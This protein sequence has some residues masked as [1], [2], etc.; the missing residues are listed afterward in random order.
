MSL[1]K[2][3]TKKNGYI[4]LII[5]A[6]VT[7]IISTTDG[8]DFDVYLGAAKKLSDGQNIYAPPFVKGL[9]YYYS[10][11]FALLLIPFHKFIFVTEF[12]WLL[13]SYYWLYRIWQLCKDYFDID[14]LT[15][16]QQNQWLLFTFLLALQFIMYN[17]SVIQVTIFLLWAIL[18]SLRL[19][20]QKKEI[21]AGL[22]LA[23]IINIKVMPV[24]ILP[25]LFYR[26]YFKS[27]ITIIIASVA[28]IYLPAIFI[29]NDY[30]NF[31]LAEWWKIINPQNKEH[32]FET[33]IGPHSLVALI[34]VYLIDTTGDLPYKRNFVNLDAATVKLVINISRLLLLA[35]SFFYLRSMPFRKETNKLKS[36]WEISYFLLIIPLLM[37]HQMKY[38]FLFSLPM[39]MYLLYF[40]FVTWKLPRS[41]AYTIVLIVFLVTQI[42]FYSP[43]YGRDLIGKF[44]FNYTQHFRYLTI[45]TLLLIPVSLY[46]SPKKISAVKKV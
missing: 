32:L 39:I 30:N 36:F 15:G 25:Y 41:T 21:T 26:G 7:S 22:L 16:K 27:I 24:L 28:L 37:P 19:I 2:Y 44:L 42:F 9:Q 46:C 38:A 12:I 29:G 34:P 6:V 5:I 18:E 10:V 35:I 17:I 43:V 33:N 1:K 14:R 20:Q 31:L 23:L 11:F 3:V 8:G 13:A 4:L 40:Y 45:A